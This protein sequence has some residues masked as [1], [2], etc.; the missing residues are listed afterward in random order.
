MGDVYSKPPITIKFHEL[1]VGD[2]KGVV[3]EIA[4]YLEKD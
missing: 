1:H 3:G 4:S 2:I